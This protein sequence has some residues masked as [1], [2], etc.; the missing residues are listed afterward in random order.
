[1]KC[2]VLSSASIL[3]LSLMY[4][5]LLHAAPTNSNDIDYNDTGTAGG[6]GGGGHFHRHNYGINNSQ[7][8]YNTIFAHVKD[9][10]MYLPVMMTTF[11][12]TMN[13]FPKFAEDNNKQ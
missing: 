1:M 13:G 3:I 10:F 5:Q 6:G 8:D 12:E 4:L 2:E 11:K 9:F 7:I